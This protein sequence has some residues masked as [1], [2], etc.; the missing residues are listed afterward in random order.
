VK[1]PLRAATSG[2]ATNTMLVNAVSATTCR[3]NAHW[4]GSPTMKCESMFSPG[5]VSTEP[6]NALG[7]RCQP[8][9]SGTFL[10]YQRA[11][12]ICSPVWRISSTNWTW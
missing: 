2:V 12:A 1:S 9:G 11:S 4:I 10:A 6:E 5:L 8:A 3:V 7:P